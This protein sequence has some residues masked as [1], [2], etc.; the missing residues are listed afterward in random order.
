[1]YRLAARAPVGPPLAGQWPDPRRHRHPHLQRWP[2][3]GRD[4]G[5]TPAAASRP[6]SSASTGTSDEPI[7]QMHYC[8]PITPPIAPRLPQR[9]PLTIH[10]AGVSK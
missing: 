1:M 3:F 8:P 7:A 4:P 2:L 9:E 10:R 6:P 5:G